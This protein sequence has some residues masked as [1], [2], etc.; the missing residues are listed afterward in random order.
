MLKWLRAEMYFIICQ[1]FFN[2]KT[3]EILTIRLNAVKVDGRE[4]MPR[5]GTDSEAS[6]SR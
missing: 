3:F 4:G 1:T 6:S 5:V 2:G